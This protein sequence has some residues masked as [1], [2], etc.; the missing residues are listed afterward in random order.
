MDPDTQFVPLEVGRV[1]DCIDRRVMGQVCY[2]S[3]KGMEV[4]RIPLTDFPAV[5]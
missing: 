4:L 2:V 5:W 3:A 1:K